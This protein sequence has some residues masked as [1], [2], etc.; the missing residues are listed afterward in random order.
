[1]TCGVTCTQRQ[2]NQGFCLGA[3]VTGLQCTG[4]NCDNVRLR[5][6]PTTGSPLGTDQCFWTDFFSEEQGSATQ[7]NASGSLRVAGAE[8]T[9]SKCDNMRFF[10][11]P[12]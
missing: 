7:F 4:S 10:L 6:T 9:G 12:M 8:C 5:C 11:C 2:L 1:V 3:T